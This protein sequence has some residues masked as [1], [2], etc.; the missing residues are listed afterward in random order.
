MTAEEASFMEASQSIQD[1][2]KKGATEADCKDL[3]KTTCKEVL[4]EVSKDQKVINSQSSGIHC[5]KLGAGGVTIAIRHYHKRVQQWKVSKKKIITYSLT[6]VTVSS[7]TLKSLRNG[8]CGW[9][10]SS[11]SYRSAHAKYVRAVKYERTVRSWV[12]EAK[13]AITVA[14]RVQRI[15]QEKCRCNVKK[16][17]DTMWRTINNQ[18]KRARQFVALQKCTM[19]QCVLAG[20]PVNN[21]KCSP[22]LP[23]LR[24]KRLYYLVERISS[25]LCHAHHK[26]STAKIAAKERKSKAHA[27]ERKAKYVKKERAAKAARREKS[28]KAAR[29]ERA[30]KAKAREQKAKHH[31]RRSK[32][33]ERASKERSSKIERRNKHNAAIERRNKGW[34][35]M[36]HHRWHGWL[37]NMD[38]NI[39]WQT[40]GH[41]FVSGLRSFHHNGYEDR[42]FSPLLTNVGS[43]QAHKHWSGWVNNMDAYF[44]YDCP[45]NYAVTGFI[46]YHSNRH[47]DRRWRFQCARFHHLGVRRLGWPGW[48]TGWDATFHI[49]C[50][51]NPAVG[52]SSTHNN[53]REDRIWRVRCG[54]FYVRM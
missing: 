1:M 22:K 6:K 14:K 31:E 29:A 46:S 48:Q 30:A 16:R 4:T 23:K 45:T 54:R 27:R 35:R 39:N 51:A 7:R 38:G 20:V 12:S 47:E 42:R 25:R 34:L 8:K 33:A 9:V 37:N 32:A 11:R 21:K 41:T 52:F 40:H 26:E 49:G 53:G 19:M 10:F 44:H 3:A 18:K 5:N 17:R 2:K 43:T 28:A 13:R 24:N 50:G 15:Q 36:T